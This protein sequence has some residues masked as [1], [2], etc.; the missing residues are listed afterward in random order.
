MRGWGRRSG[1]MALVLLAAGLGSSARAAGPPAPTGLLLVGTVVTM[2][3]DHEV[4]ADGRVLVKNGK[5]ERIWTGASPPPGV[6]LTGV[7]TVSSG[8][9]GLIFPGLINLHDHPSYDFLPRWLPP[10]AH[11]QAN[12]G[13]PDGTE[14]Y[15]NRYQW[16]KPGTAAVEFE[17]LVRN[18]YNAV[19]D[20]L[21]S[22][23]DDASTHAEARAALGGQTAIQGTNEQAVSLVRNV[24]ALN[25]GDD[26][27]DNEV[28]RVTLPEFSQNKAGG[29]RARMVN[30]TL[31][32]WLVH[33]A[34]GVRDGQRREGDPE[35]DSARS[36][37]DTL[38]Q[39]R[40]LTDAT[41]VVHGT[42]L[43]RS[44][45]KEMREAPA[46]EADGG[47]GDG[48]G[49]KL[50]WS[51][52]SNLVL[53][54]QTTEIYDAL[55]EGL[56][57]SLGTDWTPS[58]SNTLLDEL[59]VA[60]VAMRHQSLLGGSRE[61]VPG[62]ADEAQ[63]DRT[64]VD[65][66]T[67]NPALTLRWPEVGTIAEGKVADLLLVR[68][69]AA[70]PT[71][72]MP[73]TPYRN[74]IDATARDVT[75]V[76]VDG[77]PIAGEVELL[78]RLRVGHDV[79]ESPSGQYRKGVHVAVTQSDDRLPTIEQRLRAGLQALGGEQPRGSAAKKGET[80]YGYL[81]KNMQGDQ[82][83]QKTTYD[84]FLSKLKTAY[85]TSPVGG[86][87]LERMQL[88]PLLTDDDDFSF[89]VLGQRLTP[90]GRIDDKT[91][92]Y[93]IYQANLNHIQA[94]ENPFAQPAFFDRWY[95]SP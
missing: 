43:E 88:P 2:N 47:P 53:Y 45:F 6:D 57:V 26:H 77:N 59:K 46:A 16:N 86:V 58:G 78:K 62:L 15:A 94:G 33:L 79:V 21:P 52:L 71:G 38:R 48:L 37:L 3:A 39:Q 75:L 93:R 61:N 74:L 50:V 51:P 85:P 69:P 7:A 28:G 4:M 44:D 18:P 9:G 92:P 87:N 70:T 34:E 22:G 12:L 64:L 56:V 8:P 80:F 24:D 55:A 36:E 13:R 19:T 27:V 29:I 68:R 5:I 73:D 23:K 31:K 81:W 82:F 67:R 40:L 83:N 17:R 54:G 10:T 60:D 91:P 35:A 76:T 90:S 84:E 63:L 25:F 89:A 49:A 42:G 72:G 30:G 66:V 1:L 32:A 41:V 95:G 65:M 20:H 14:P 11:V